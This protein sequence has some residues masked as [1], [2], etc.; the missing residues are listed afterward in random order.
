MTDPPRPRAAPAQA[1]WRS[2]A[3]LSRLSGV[4]ARTL[5]HYDELGLLPPAGTGSGGLRFY[6]T[7][8]MLRLQRILVLKQF[9]LPLA[10]IRALLEGEADPVSALRRHRAELES[11]RQRLGRQLQTLDNTITALVEGTPL[12]TDDLYTGFDHATHRAEVAERWGSDTAAASDSWWSRLGTEGHTRLFAEQ[13]AIQADFDAVQRVGQAPDSPAGLAA[14]ERQLRW[15]RDA[16]TG[17]GVP[18]TAEYVAGLGDM[19]VED[20]RFAKNY[21]AEHP[22]GAAFVRDAMN[23][24]VAGGF[25]VAPSP[26]GQ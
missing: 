18:F 13:R 22:G 17:T 9:G 15:L 23:A 16:A 8:G 6:D 10:E 25:P 2:T 24:A 7:A 11:E 4:T 26:A 20:P 3:E 19:Y 14:A 21:T 12:M 5:R 1:Q